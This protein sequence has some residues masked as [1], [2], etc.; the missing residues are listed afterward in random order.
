MIKPDTLNKLI[1][2]MIETNREVTIA[3]LIMIA[4]MIG[5]EQLLSLIR[6]VKSKITLSDLDGILIYLDDDS[7]RYLTRLVD[8]RSVTFS[9]IR[10]V[11]AMLPQDCT[12]ALVAICQDTFSLCQFSDVAVFLSDAGKQ[13]LLQKVELTSV[14]FGAICDIAAIAG[15]DLV[16]ELVDLA[17]KNGDIPRKDNLCAALMKKETIE[18]LFALAVENKDAAVIKSLSS[19]M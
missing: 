10:N 15:P 11:A 2:Q 4:P 19:Y 18:K 12:E 8:E 14:T 17:L 6:K 16:D 5:N 1:D 13:K 7:K 3:S 9:G